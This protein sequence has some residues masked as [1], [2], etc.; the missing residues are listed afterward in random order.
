MAQKLILMVYAE[1][2]KGL[3]KIDPDKGAKRVRSIIEPLRNA[4][5]GN[6]FTLF[7][8]R[9]RQ[10]ID[11][12][13]AIADVLRKRI[14]LH[15]KYALYCSDWGHY[16]SFYRYIEA[17]PENC[18]VAIGHPPI[19]EKFPD[20]LLEQ[21]SREW[22]GKHDEKRGCCQG[23]VYDLSTKTWKLFPEDFMENR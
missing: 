15:T 2:I 21:V 17:K 13:I 9:N 23:Y 6:Y 18:I 7:S 19:V 16:E 20:F 1:F 22:R 5:G 12:A 4:T 8:S 3:D 14:N 10:T 11:T